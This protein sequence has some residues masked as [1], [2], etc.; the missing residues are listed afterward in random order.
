MK[1]VFLGL[2][3]VAALMM[4]PTSAK[5]DWDDHGRHRHQSNYRHRHSDHHRGSYGHYNYYRP[6][7]TVYRNIYPSCNVPNVYGG[8]GGGYGGPNTSFY[9]SGRNASFGF[10]F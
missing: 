6:P 3:A 4:T 8:Y 5:A 9:Y 10:G 7:V 1:R 2:F